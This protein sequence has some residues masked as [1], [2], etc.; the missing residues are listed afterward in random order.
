MPLVAIA[1]RSRSA[2]PVLLVLTVVS[3][4]CGPT[5]VADPSLATVDEVVDG[6]TVRLRFGPI[7]ETTRLLGVDTPESVH[8][9]APEQCFGAEATAELRRLLPSGTEVAVFRDTEGRDHYGRLLLHVRRVDDGLAINLH[10]VEHGFAAAAFYEPN[11]HDR[12]RFLDAERAAKAERRGL[13][14]AC[15][16]PDQPLD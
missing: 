7:V 13:W 4:G 16:G 9:T 14:G 11:H 5:T 2:M 3:F 10:L 6:D 15:D 12:S 8:P 1:R